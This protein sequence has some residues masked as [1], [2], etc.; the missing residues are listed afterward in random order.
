MNAAYADTHTRRA[1]DES[2]DEV[3]VVARQRDFTRND[4]SISKLTEPLLNTPQS[5]ATLSAELLRERGV[6]SLNAALRTVPGITLGAGEFSWQGN[7]PS[8]RGFSSRNDMFL[9]GIRDFGSYPRDPFNLQSIEVLMGPSSMLFGRGST[10]GVI[11]QV[12]KTPTREARTAL[13]VNIGSASTLRGTVDANR[14]LG[15]AAALRVN[16][17]AHRAEVADRDA[18]ETEKYGFATSLALGLGSATRLTLSYMHQAADNVPDYGL[19][20][21]GSKPAA[22]PR[23]N[24]YGFGSDYLDTAADILTANLTHAASESVDFSGQFRYARYRRDSRLTEPLIPAS[25]PADTPPEDITIDRHVFIG[26]SDE[27]MLFAQGNATIRFAAGGVEHA[28]VAGLEAGRESSEPTFGIGIGVPGT[29]LLDPVWDTAFSADSVAPRVSAD[30]VSTSAG[31]YLLDTL[32]LNNRWQLV[33]GLRWDRFDTDYD[34]ERFDGPATPFSGP[35]EAGTEAIDQV[36]NVLSYRTAVVYKP[37]ENGTVYLSWGTSF[38]PS[39]EGLSFITTGRALGLGN[40]GLDPEENESVEIG[41]KWALAEDRLKVSAALFQITKENA[42]VPDPDN[43]GLNVLAGEQRI[44]GLSF[45]VSGY[46]ADN[47]QLMAGYTHLD[48]EV[49]DAATGAAP[50]GSSLNDAPRHNLSFWTTY[51][52]RE[53]LLIGGG[54]GYL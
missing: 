36:D 46:L 22:V 37:A 39:A 25:V 51:Q 29:N 21:F 45:D 33:A 4:V 6:D 11:N 24:F 28:L 2:L 8:I 54:A 50:E 41:T 40:Q 16:L 44:R 17:M 23:D 47:W 48:G 32:K 53:R 26:D 13:N 5:I 9:D 27:A 14:P 10:G 1:A 19:P 35:S 31:V 43:T 38:N 12:S 7:N 15:E 49:V 52:V 30:T 3:V 42:R 20:W 34:A 18:V